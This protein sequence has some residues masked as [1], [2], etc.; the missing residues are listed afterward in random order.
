MLLKIENTSDT[1]TET[2]LAEFSKKL[3]EC[4]DIEANTYPKWIEA[5]VLEETSSSLIPVTDDLKTRIKQLMLPSALQHFQRLFS[6]RGACI[7]LHQH[8]CDAA[9]QHEY[10]L[11]LETLLTHLDSCCH[12]KQL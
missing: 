7:A 8:V 2:P 9:A 6:D 3:L 1:S 12:G 11:Q 5:S 4:I 10:A